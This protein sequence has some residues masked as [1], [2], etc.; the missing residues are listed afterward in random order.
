MNSRTE[1]R[2]DLESEK[3]NRGRTACR[4]QI[5]RLSVALTMTV[6]TVASA[7]SYKVIKS[8]GVL[9][10]VSGCHPRA[11]LLQGPDGTLYGTANEGQGPVLG[12]V[13]KLNSDGTGFRVLKWFTNS[14]E[15]GLPNGG[16]VL[17]GSTLYGTASAGG[18]GEHGVVFKVNT[19]GS[20]FE[21]IKSFGGYDGALPN[22]DLVLAGSTLYGT[23]FNGGTSSLGVVFKVNTDG[24][25][26]A[27]LKNFTGSDGSYPQAGPVLAGNTLYGTTVYG[28]SSGRGVIFTVN[29][30]GSGYAVLKNF[31]GSD[32]SNPQAGLVLTGATLYGTTFFGG[33]LYTNNSSEGR[34]VV[35]K[36]NTDGSGYTVLQSFSGPDGSYPQADLVVSGTTL[37]G[38]TYAGGDSYSADNSGYGVVFKLNTDGAGYVV[39]KNLAGGDEAYPSAGL[40][41]SSS[42]LYATASGGDSHLGVVFRV[43]TDGSAYTVLTRFS[44][45]DGSRPYAG[46]VL[47]GNRLYGTT[48]GG[49]NSGYGTVFAVNTDGSGYTVLT[50]FTGG[51]DGGNPFG[52][53]ALAGDT[54]YGTAEYGGASGCGVV[55]KVN[56]DGSGYQ[57]LKDFNEED[58]KFP[59]AGL[60]LDGNTLYGRASQGGSSGCGTLFKLNTDGSGFSVL[61]NFTNVGGTDPWP[62]LILSG[63]KLYGTIDSGGSIGGGAVFKVN[64]DGSGY[65]E[66]ESFGGDSGLSPEGELVL[67]GN[68][69]CGA[70]LLGGNYPDGGV[71]FKVNTDGAGYAELK[72]FSGPDG[73]YGH[74]GML[75]EG[76][77]LIGTTVYG[78]NRYHPPYLGDGVVFKVN[79][80]GSG[81]A[82]LKSFA[83]SDGACPYGALTLGGTV[84][85][86]TAGWGGDFDLGVV[87]SLEC[88]SVTKPP[89][90]QTAETGYTVEFHVEAAS[91]APGLGYQWYLNGTNAVVGATNDFLEL[92]SVQPAQAGAYTVVVMNMGLAVTSSPALLSVIPRVDRRVVPAVRLTGSAGSL[93]HLEYVD[94]LATSQWASLSNLT[95]TSGAA[96][97]LDLSPALPA[98][99]FYR[100]W[101][102]NGPNPALDATIATEIPLTGA[103]GSSVRVDYINA[104]GPTDAWVT[105]GTVLLTNPPQ[106]YYDLTAFRQPARLYRLVTLP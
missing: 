16:L 67:G 21:V 77:T 83:G 43:N 18:V 3:K 106:L 47:D 15:G 42:A 101:Q 6:T 66:L 37:Y 81:Y 44:G 68:T 74:G 14:V 29:T 78:G 84:V 65:Q 70:T 76:S 5:L 49:G 26:Y 73:A 69:L 45:G 89:S 105:L 46:L 87:Y 86:G 10:N 104:I 71:V 28:G 103:I 60:L 30:D 36:V 80:D 56:T 91:L 7:Q 98:Q 72:R 95:L 58:G 93:L 12:T 23:T 64:T 32:G 41:L 31:N 24:S 90:T 9:T 100:A 52:R 82:V 59:G 39:L 8:F 1:L 25:S 51:A 33:T 97:C 2:A 102:A 62:G 11:P 57:V 94:R 48:S 75:L 61:M 99:R 27:V 19:D 88:L 96:L 38:T 35:Y 34:G 17:A 55:F 63:G 50:H 22:G 53:L 13:F 54:L 79:T 20:G 85:Y 4:A 40:V 92:T